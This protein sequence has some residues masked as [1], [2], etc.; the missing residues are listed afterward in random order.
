VHGP[1][2]RSAKHPT[3]KQPVG[4]IF[5]I[6]DKDNVFI[7]VESAAQIKG[8]QFWYLWRILGL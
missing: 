4:S 7:T 1:T 6:T 5:K 3:K 2:A 8:I